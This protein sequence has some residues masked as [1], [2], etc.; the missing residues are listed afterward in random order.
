MLKSK[1]FLLSKG[2]VLDQ[3]SDFLFQEIGLDSYLV[4]GV[5]AVVINDSVT[6]LT[7][8][9]D[10]YPSNPVDSL[11]P[12]EGAIFTSDVASDDFDIRFLFNYPIDPQSID[13]G[14]FS[15]DGVDL[16][17]SEVYVDPNANNYYVK[18]SASAP[19]Q[20]EAFHSYQISSSLKRKDGS[21]FSYTPIGG[22]VFHSLSS[23]HIGD[24]TPDYVSRRRGKL[25]VAV[26]RLSKAINP[27]QG[28]TEYLSQRQ[29]SED[30]LVAFTTAT[31]LDNLVDVYF[32]YLSKIEPQIVSGFPLNNSLLPD[33]SAPDKVSLVFSTKLDRAKLLNTN[34]LFSIEEG[35]GTST[36]VATSDIS[37]LDDQR[38]VEIDVTSYF[39][40]QKVYSILAR[41][42]ILS[43]DGLAKEKPEQWTIHISAY[44]GGGGIPT[45]ELSGAPSDAKYVVL[46]SHALL[47]NEF[48][49]TGVTGLQVVTGAGTVTVVG[50]LATTTSAGMAVF[51]GNQFEILQG[52]VTVNE[53]GLAHNELAN[54]LLDSH[55]QYLTSGRATG[56]FDA[57]IR[58]SNAITG[59][60]VGTTI[61][62]SGVGI[63]E[64]FGNTSNPH[65]TTASQVGAPT[66]AQFT[67]HTGR[68]DNPHDVTATQIGAALDA[69]LDAHT[70]NSSNPH[71]VTAAQVGSPTLAVFT[72]HTG[73]LDNPHQVTASQV[74]SPTIAQFTGHTGHVDPHTGYLLANGGRTVLTELL[75]ANAATSLSAYMRK[76]EVDAA[77]NFLLG[78]QVAHASDSS[79]HNTLATLSGFYQSKDA[80]LTA[81]AN[82]TTSSGAFIYFT[83]VDAVVTGTITPYARTLLDDTT[84]AAARSTLQLGGLAIESDLSAHTLDEF[85][86]VKYGTLADKDILVYN[87][88]AGFWENTAQ[89]PGA[90]GDLSNVD[91]AGQQP[92]NKIF[93]Y[94]GTAQQ[95]EPWNI[96]G[97]GGVQ[98]AYNNS[99]SM[100]TISGVSQHRSLFATGG[101]FVTG[102]G[103]A[104]LWTGVNYTIPS[105]TL[106]KYG[107]IRV[108]I[109]AAVKSATTTMVFKQFVNTQ[110]VWAAP[111]TVAAHTGFKIVNITYDFSNTGT[112]SG[113]FLGGWASIHPVPTTTVTGLGAFSNTGF[114][115]A[116]FSASE[117]M[118]Y[119]TLTGNVSLITVI[120][121][122]VTGASFRLN[123]VNVSLIPD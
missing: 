114:I 59:V 82:L 16:S 3:V 120:Q 70:S 92:G 36:A 84:P 52:R 23:A 24:V 86:D 83:G 56:W 53:S 33:V 117:P 73:R 51:S 45:G 118:A 94:D 71:N 9:Y 5:Q 49:L 57:S 66:L 54:L 40:Q 48:V 47:P 93:V 91:D 26:L 109:Q 38:T 12:R 110:V 43:V 30:R 4:R 76:N 14:T 103:T 21:S 77:D 115:E 15:I 62:L 98:P 68:L 102:F 99:T 96:T 69:D 123:S 19:Y 67:G 111:A 44:E 13:N 121:P 25:A 81:I 55:I 10:K 63:N 22:Y 65:S 112:L 31:R 34:N 27:Q 106:G 8:L 78:L 7:L 100:L 64:H 107:K 29:I 122:A 88:S 39:T 35:F 50:Q 18:I 90:I 101:V 79:I 89:D 108:D 2:Q 1:S 11:A 42:G 87:E 61:V 95:W 17:A 72:G 20:S 113:N 46:G 119:N 105:G 104:P 6:Q 60:T 97:A 74:G 58:Y 28:I 80:T 37:L 41:P 116:L 85:S 32:I 75:A